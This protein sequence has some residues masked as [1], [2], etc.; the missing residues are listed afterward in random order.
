MPQ[1]KTLFGLDSTRLASG[2]QVQQASDISSAAAPAPPR[3]LSLDNPSA[4]D[5]RFART[6]AASAAAQQMHAEASSPST[7]V[8]P[9]QPSG[10]MRDPVEPNRDAQGRKSVGQQEASESKL[11]EVLKA[12]R[13]PLRESS[14]ALYAKYMSFLAAQAKA[15]G[16]RSMCMFGFGLGEV[17]LHLL[18]A[19]ASPEVLPQTT[20]MMLVVDELSR[21]G[22][23]PAAKMI[24]SDPRIGP[25]FLAL[26]APPVSTSARLVAEFTSLVC[27]TNVIIPRVDG[28]NEMLPNGDGGDAPGHGDGDAEKLEAE[29]RKTILCAGA[30][31]QAR[32]PP[33]RQGGA[34]QRQ[35]LQEPEPPAPARYLRMLDELLN[36]D[37][38]S[39]KADPPGAHGEDGGGDGQTGGRLVIVDGWP[40]GQG[41]CQLV[42]RVWEAL[43]QDKLVRE[44]VRH[45]LASGR[46]G[47][48]VGRYLGTQHDACTG[49]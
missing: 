2:Q 46:H 24:A 8:S 14:P 37:D 4:F 13:A 32:G 44:L 26:R 10:S 5:S 27:D 45:T 1:V 39:N 36:D 19:S 23:L 34:R 38:D 9:A 35:L 25:R 49:A 41:R 33:S 6:R 31:T 29:L 12:A 43:V 18:L 42:G 20:P 21:A 47:F 15:P 17:P 22:Q 11:K 40:C 30:L 16:L 48:V 3:P 7:T 28:S